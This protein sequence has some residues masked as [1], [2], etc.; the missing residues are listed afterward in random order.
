MVSRS[1][2]LRDLQGIIGDPAAKRGKPLQENTRDKVIDM[3]RD[4]E[5]TREMPGERN[6]VSIRGLDGNKTYHQKHLIL[7]NLRELYHHFNQKYP[8]ERISVSKFI[9]LRPK[10]A[11]T[12]DSKDTTNACVCAIHQNVELM[13][14]IVPG[15]WDAKKLLAKMVC[16]VTDPFCMLHGCQNCPGK[17]QI[18]EELEMLFEDNGYSLD[19]VI[20]YSA[21]LYVDRTD[22]KVIEA[23]IEDFCTK[24]A[25]GLESLSAHHYI[26]RFQA[27]ALKAQKEGLKPEE[28]IVIGD[29]AENYSFVV[30]DAIQGWHWVNSQATLH[31]FCIYYKDANE[32]KHLSLCIISNHMSHNTATVHSFQ[33][34]LI[35]YIKQQLPNV[36]FI[37]Y[38]SDGA[39]SQYKNFKNFANIRFHREDFGLDCDWHFFAT[40]HGKGPCDGV[41]GVVKR[42][43]TRYSKQLLKSGKERLLTAHQL[44]LFAKENIQNVYVEYVET[45]VVQ[46]NMEFL[47]E[48]FATACKVPGCRD[49]HY[50]KPLSTQSMEIN[51][52]SPLPGTDHL[53]AGYTFGGDQEDGT[54]EVEKIIAEVGKYYAVLYDAVWWLGLVLEHSEDEDDYKIRFMNRTGSSF[55]WPR[56]DDICWVPCQH[57][58]FAVETPM[59]S[60]S[61]RSYLLTANEL[62][63]IEK[64][65]FMAGLGL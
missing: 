13:A 44:Y 41:G 26:A 6:T 16:D 9:A 43:A 21:W 56:R 45:E 11:V 42:L 3:Y 36:T 18:R 24:L 27:G 20:K 39:A 55:S 48:R 52:V 25:C 4:Q 35:Q 38:F 31:P 32:L 30:Q 15:E 2:K 46:L 54:A 61:G 37:K 28:V 60:S 58:L 1:R 40:S 49:Q 53:I 59:A 34:V 23:N 51:R 22:I 12:V 33:R 63:E 50:F 47:K 19:D 65:N 57:V 29:F 7:V 62:Q 14:E 10:W 64:G 17:E 8:E 5:Y